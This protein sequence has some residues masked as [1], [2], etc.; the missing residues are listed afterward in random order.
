MI[1]RLLGFSFILSLLTA[2]AASAPA[3]PKISVENPWARPAIVGS[4][5]ATPTMQGMSGASGSGTPDMQGMA[6]MAASGPTSAAYFVIVNQGSE[7]DTLVGAS[8]G[9]ASK[10]EM[11]ETRIVND[12]AEMVPIPSLDVPAGGRVEFKPGGYHVMLEGL[13]QDL[14]VGETIQLTLQFAKSGAITLEVPI[15]A[16][17]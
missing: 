3:G 11:H 16:G 4:M 1:R 14:K 6:G 9:V 13:N 7:A 8:S 10:A 15:Q 2:C 12:V 5:S 17:N